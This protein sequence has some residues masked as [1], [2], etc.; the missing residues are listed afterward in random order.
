MMAVEVS[1]FT[2]MKS[3]VTKDSF[4]YCCREKQNTNLP[5]F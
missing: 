3:S 2:L 4:D 5:S 1:K